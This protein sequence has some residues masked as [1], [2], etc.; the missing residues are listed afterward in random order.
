MIRFR[1]LTIMKS[2]TYWH[3]KKQKWR[4]SGFTVHLKFGDYA[5]MFTLF[6]RWKK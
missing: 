6:K 4:C 1:N 2:D 5:I 3:P